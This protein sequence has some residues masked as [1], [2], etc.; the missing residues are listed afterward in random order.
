MSNYRS[1][2]ASKYAVP[3][4]AVV[5][6][7]GACSSDSNDASGESDSPTST[8]Q[9]PQSETGEPSQSEDSSHAD[10]EQPTGGPSS[11]DGPLSGEFD[12]ESGDL[13][14]ASI[15]VGSTV[16]CGGWT[17]KLVDFQ[18]KATLPPDRDF[19]KPYELE[20]ADPD[21]PVASATLE[22]TEIDNSGGGSPDAYTDFVGML[23]AGD[24]GLYTTTTSSPLLQD[25]TGTDD[26]ELACIPKGLTTC[27]GTVYFPIEDDMDLSKGPVYVQL[28]SPG[29][30][31]E[32]GV[33]LV[34]E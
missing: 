26:D 8:S 5:A 19:T 13:V 34:I 31:E 32:M 6:L 12:C 3:L 18:A 30:A 22:I 28:R 1:R 27:T 11:L 29:G 4:V 25:A 15:T 17:V 24:P 7:L 14:N 23:F 33:V 10:E 21:T 2:N 9:E 20:P 16:T